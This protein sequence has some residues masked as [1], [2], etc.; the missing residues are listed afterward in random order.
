MANGEGIGEE[1][2]AEA[3]APVPARGW[4]EAA[5]A[6]MVLVWGVNF[7]VV[8][9]ALEDFEPL[10]FNALRFALAS[11][12]VLGVL[13]AQGPLALPAR[14]D[15]PRILLLGLVGNLVY[16]LCFILGLDRSAAGTAAVI[17]A[18][19]PLITAFLSMLTGHERPGP[20]TWMGGALSI[21][22]IA[23][24]S[25]A[26]VRVGGGRALV[27]S[28]VL[29][30]ACFAW[31]FYT[32]GS[33]PLVARYG[34]VRTTVW[35]LWIGAAGLLVVGTPA[36]LAQRWD[37]IR[38]EA[39]GGLVFSATLAIALSY[40]IWYRGVERIGNTRT[41]IF[42]NLT[43]LVAL[44]AGALLLGERPSLQALAGA[45]LTLG[46]VMVVRGDP[47]SAA[48]AAGTTRA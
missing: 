6:V 29:L 38:P 40:L 44:A 4:T 28:L 16:Q 45:A 9:H 32:V 18:L 33:R 12:L 43:P 24:V 26:G 21:V 42:S 1:L 25:G 10:A 31:A 13:R 41:A 15:A 27:G 39:W 7:A 3:T 36:L 46:G 48:P 37:R 30:L 17:L 35:T 34:S 20:R 14:A 11:V 19:T 5:L 22:G 8:K 2:G 47:G 23:L